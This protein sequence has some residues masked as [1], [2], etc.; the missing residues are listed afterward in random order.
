MQPGKEELISRHSVRVASQPGLALKP[1]PL[2]LA[3]VIEPPL[4]SDVS[5]GGINVFPA[6]C[7]PPIHGTA[8]T[9][10]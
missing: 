3:T 10:L 5:C 6:L 8:V 7:P 2:G 1:F 4:H 9:L